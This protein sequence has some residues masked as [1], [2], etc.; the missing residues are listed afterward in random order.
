MEAL[1]QVC[2]HMSHDLRAPLRAIQ[3]FS[4]CLTEGYGDVLNEEGREYL[5]RI[6]GASTR[7]EKM[8]EGLR[9]FGQLSQRKLV[10]RLVKLE[11]VLGGAIGGL[12]GEIRS[13]EAKIGVRQPLPQVWTSALLLEEILTH[14]LRNAITYVRPKTR[15]NVTIYVEE[16]WSH[17]RIHIQDNGIGIA[18]EH[19]ERIFWIFERLAPAAE[20]Q[21]IGL[22]LAMVRNGMRRLCGRVR[23]ESRSGGGSCFVL[24]LPKRVPETQSV[25]V[26]HPGRQA[27]N[28]NKTI[29]LAEDDENDFLLMK[30]AFEKAGVGEYFRR[31]R[32]GEEVI[33]Y[34]KGDQGFSDRQ[35]F[36]LPSLLLLDL[37]MP[38]KSGIEVLNWIRTHA[39]FKTMV[40][41]VLTSS[42]NEDDI[43][44]AYRHYA[45][46]YLVK[47]VSLEALTEM[48]QKIKGYWLELNQNPQPAI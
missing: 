36:P 8:V 28:R 48:T 5:Q 6:S 18:P 37:K 24:E 39:Q 15:P 13:C 42:N 43:V 4:S 32:D 23:L 27:M 3:G 31:V 2:Y 16:S 17:V 1:E 19:Q 29:L 33:R 14:V 22:G 34:L 11:R 40:V 12:A 7:L 10:P 47:P 41:T 35:E 45:N 38:L 25:K 30:L 21:S 46:S 44:N 20:H 26:P 9:D